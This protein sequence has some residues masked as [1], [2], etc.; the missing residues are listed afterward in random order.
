M[1]GVYYNSLLLKRFNLTEV[2]YGTLCVFSEV[3]TAL[4]VWAGPVWR[5][6]VVLEDQ[7]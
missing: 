5:S 1:T 2:N 7:M 4:G 3:R 6:G